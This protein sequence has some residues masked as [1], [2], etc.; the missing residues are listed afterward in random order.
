[1]SSFV[2]Q[3]FDVVAPV[4]KIPAKVSTKLPDKNRVIKNSTI[5]R[6]VPT[7]QAN[8][9]WD[10]GSPSS[11]TFSIASKGFFVDPDNASLMFSVK[12]KKTSGALQAWDTTT[13]K[14]AI[15]QNAIAVINTAQLKVGGITVD[16][17]TNLEASV[18]QELLLGTSEPWYN[19]VGF[20]QMKLWDHSATATATKKMVG[21]LQAN[22]APNALQNAT[23]MIARYID[24]V[25]VYYDVSVP[26]TPVA[27]VVHCEVPL[28]ILFGFFRQ[29]SYLPL[30]FM[31]GMEITLN[32]A[33]KEQCLFCPDK[34]EVALGLYSLEIEGLRIL[35]RAVEL[36]PDILRIYKMLVE[37]DEMGISLPF[38]TKATTV[39]QTAASAGTTDIAVSRASPYVKNVYVSRKPSDCQNRMTVL[40]CAAPADSLDGAQLSIQSVH[41]PNFG[42]A[43]K[44]DLLNISLQCGHGS[45]SCNA[46]MSYPFS[47]NDY[48]GDNVF[49]TPSNTSFG[50]LDAFKI[51]NGCAVLGFSLEKDID[52]EYDIDGLD[53][54]ALGS[55]FSLTLAEKNVAGATAGNSATRSV[56]TT[57]KYLRI[58]TLRKSVM[59]VAG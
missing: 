42:I 48:Y 30:P 12:V 27:Q 51:S 18:H 35:Y 28:A 24:M 45:S 26:A 59:S 13:L 39:S 50:L 4:E 1:M 38:D 36:E 14:L 57:F 17:I 55:T 19:T 52:S 41:V 3:P 11:T 49:N 20:N 58:L 40:N 8:I 44:G 21:Q 2:S 10:N 16:D 5:E 43:T 15:L 54:S 34:T 9:N 46:L 37:D 56:L 22:A 32:W 29:E 7:S 33:P 25:N 31:N 23:G 53:S 47:Y 6:S